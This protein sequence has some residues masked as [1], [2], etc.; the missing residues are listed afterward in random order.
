MFIDFWETQ[1]LIGLAIANH[2]SF[3]GRLPTVWIRIPKFSK[4]SLWL[5]IQEWWDNAAV[6][7][8]SHCLIVY[9]QRTVFCNGITTSNAW[10][11]NDAF[12]PKEKH[13]VENRS[14]GQSN[15]I[16]NPRVATYSVILVNALHFL[17]LNSFICKEGQY[18]PPSR[19]L[20]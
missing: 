16:S 12:I 15:Q 13:T 10:E 4:H 1:L 6:W 3:L 5:Q 14:L 19:L 17:S 11:N 7:P 18:H 20:R 8:I 9:I 2:L